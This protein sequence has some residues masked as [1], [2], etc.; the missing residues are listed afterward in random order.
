MNI[1]FD[2]DYTI[3]SMDGSLRPDTVGVFEQIIK[4]GHTIYIWSG[5]GLRWTEVKEHK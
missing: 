1:F 3:L 5:Q 2:V 4:D